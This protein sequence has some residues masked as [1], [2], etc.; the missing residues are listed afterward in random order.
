MAGIIV[1]PKAYI[2]ELLR[3]VFRDFGGVISPF[4][5]WL[6]LRGIHTLHVRMP[7]HC[8]NAQRVAEF[9][10]SAPEGRTSELSWAPQ[11]TRGTS[12]RRS[13]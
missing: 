3:E 9:S 11:N 13:R 10:R 1:G 5:A 8:S 6:I 2:S 7:V 12:W 4:N